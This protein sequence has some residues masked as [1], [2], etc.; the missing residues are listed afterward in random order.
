MRQNRTG[1]KSEHWARTANLTY[2]KHKLPKK[3]RKRPRMQGILILKHT[4]G[5]ELRC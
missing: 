3:G 5:G 2:E 1:T 4:W